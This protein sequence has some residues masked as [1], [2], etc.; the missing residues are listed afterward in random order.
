MHL[1]LKT[2]NTISLVGFLLGL[3]GVAYSIWILIMESDLQAIS[4]FVRSIAFI[5][6][7]VYLLIRGN[8]QYPAG[9]DREVWAITLYLFVIAMF[10]GFIFMRHSHTS[11][12]AGIAI[13]MI[14][15]LFATEYEKFWRRR[16]R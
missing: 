8:D 3:S 16:I 14:V 11:Y 10:S 6:G 4:L 1:E 13:F 2:W 15:L 9:I 7:A 12:F 5:T